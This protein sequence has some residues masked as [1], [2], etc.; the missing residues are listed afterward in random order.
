MRHYQVL[1][2]LLLPATIGQ[3]PVTPAQF[4]II[5]SPPACYATNLSLN[6]PSKALS[7]FILWTTLE[8]R[9]SMKYQ[10]LKYLKCNHIM[11][12]SK[13]RLERDGLDAIKSL[14]AGQHSMLELF[15]IFLKSPCQSHY[16]ILGLAD[17]NVLIS[18]PNVHVIFQ[19][20]DYMLMVMLKPISHSCHDKTK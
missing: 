19:Q 1:E 13:S 2:S 6:Q 17:I 11:Y 10:T 20:Y 9:T 18:F 3:Y 15:I 4:I 16:L 7:L 8:L 5:P 14:V 12:L